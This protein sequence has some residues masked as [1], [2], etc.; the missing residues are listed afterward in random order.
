MRL[1]KYILCCCCVVVMCSSCVFAS[2]K[3]KPVKTVVLVDVQEVSVTGTVLAA[4][5]LAEGGAI[6]L[7]PFKA[8]PGAEATDELDRISMMMIKGIRE[9]IADKK[10]SLKVVEP[11]E[12]S[13]R[14]AMQGYIEEYS[15]TGRLKR[16]MLRPNQSSLVVAGEVWL[17]SNGQR[18]LSFSTDKRFHSKKEKAVNVAY[19]LGREIGDY[20]SSHVK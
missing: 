6:A 17:I 19:A 16:M 15:K 9:S 10:S 8:G 5:V 12:E 18:L 3:K 1:F 14:I 2:K 20:I 7:V 13:P 11:T 4:D